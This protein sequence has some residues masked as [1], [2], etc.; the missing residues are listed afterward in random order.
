MVF[1]IIG[2]EDAAKVRS[3]FTWLPEPTRKSKQY[4]S[5][6]LELLLPLP[7]RGSI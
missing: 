2:T 4:L 3:D 5:E 6:L 7:A 1:S